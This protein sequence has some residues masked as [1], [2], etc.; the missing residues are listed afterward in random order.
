MQVLFIKSKWAK[1]KQSEKEYNFMVEFYKIKL[2]A[3]K[4]KK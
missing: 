4:I 1:N 3:R 2:I